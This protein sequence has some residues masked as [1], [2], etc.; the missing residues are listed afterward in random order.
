VA[1]YLLDSNDPENLPADRGITAQLYGGGPEVRLLQEMALGIG[2]WR[3]LRALGL[4]P[5]VCHL[6]EG[7]A[8]FT[9]LERAR[10]HASVHGVAFDVALAA[11]RA[12][13]VFT[14]HTPVGAGFDRFATDLVAT[15]LGAYAREEL[16]L[17][18]SEL[19]AMGRA[20]PTDGSEPLNMAWLATRCCGAVNAVSRRHRD[21]SRRIF[22]PLFPRWPEAE[23]PIGYVT[24]GVHVP[25]WD[26]AGAD[27]LW[28]QA[29]GPHP[30]NGLRT[31]HDEGIAA[32]D[33]VELWQMRQRARTDLVT[34]V[35]ERLALQLEGSG[36]EG[37]AIDAAANVL[38]A[39]ALT[40]GFARRFAEYKRPTLLLRDPERLARLLGDPARPV[41][42]V[43]AGKAHPQDVAGQSLL[44]E[45]VRFSRRPDVRPHAV[46]LADYDL[47]LAEQLVRGVDLWINTPRPPWEACGT[48]GMKILV[49]GGLNLSFVDGW[50]AEAFRDD[51]GWA[52]SVSGGGDDD[53][54]DAAQLYSVLEQQV[55]PAF[56]RRDTKGLPPN[57]LRK[58]RASMASLTP[59]YSADR[60][61]REYCDRY[62]LPAAA[63]FA[64]RVANE[65]TEAAALV[66]L[67]RTMETHGGQL[68]FGEVRASTEGA[69]LRFEVPLYVDDIDPDA[70]RVELYAD[71][72]ENGV[73]ELVPMRRG[74]PLVGA[75]GFA[76]LAEVRNVRPSRD[77]TPRVIAWHP[78]SAGPLDLPFIL[79]AS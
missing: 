32:R 6:N 28:T 41:Q 49:N 5:S 60:A 67:K 15:Y 38:N 35:R 19:M 7:H 22:Q 39:D 66:A 4:S 62:Y 9:A 68:R 52:P 12:G 42:I 77:Y 63:R 54:E 24:N 34:F 71:P 30:W 45:W 64:R 70:L 61:V 74:S 58:M 44:S 33:D 29:C 57:W 8:A 48:S 59:V 17:S 76:Y 36:F 72:L 2:G 75:K 13:N 20:D 16:G 46:F 14:T 55:I 26:S 1:L 69:V 43:I 53:E 65:G 78:T 50:W 37:K 25:S 27:A 18:V 21:V 51:V 47:R 23:V 40:L 10:D 31:S 3:L 56:Y 73:P 11:T 79:W